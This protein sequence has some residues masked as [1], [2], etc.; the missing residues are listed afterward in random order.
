VTRG[1]RPDQSPQWQG[2]FLQRH[3]LGTVYLESALKWFSPLARDLAEHQNSA[4]RPILVA[5][6]GCQGSGKTTVSDFLCACLEAE[7][8][9]HTVVLSLDDFYLTHTQRQVLAQTVHPLLMTRGVPGTHDMALL[10]QTL[11]G[12]LDTQRCEPVAIPRFDKAVDDRREPPDWDLVSTPVHIIV[13]EG[14][15]LGALPQIPDALAQPINALEQLEDSSAQWRGYSN[16]S[17]SREFEP[18]YA[19]VDQWVMLRA[20]S[21]EC[22]FAWRQE[23]ERKLAATLLSGQ[24]SRLMDD[25]ALRRFIQHYERLTRQCLDTLPDTVDHLFTLNEQRQ[26]TA[27]AHHQHAGAMP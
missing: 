7:Y 17:L 18:L 23:Q 21:F 14:W 8:A 11:E 13:L 12:L 9:L 16:A 6:N 25:D 15:C 10:R 5:I 3:Q 2:D 1:T 27:H 4:G 20:P 24:A 26:I 19:L 22:V